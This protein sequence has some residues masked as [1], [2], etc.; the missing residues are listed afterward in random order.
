M[1]KAIEEGF[2]DEEVAEAISGIIDSR[3]RT[4]AN[5][6][7]ISGMLHHAMYFNRELSHFQEI[8]D[9]IASMTTEHVNEAFRKYVSVEK[10]TVV[11]AG[12]FEAAA[13]R[14]LEATAEEE[15][16]PTGE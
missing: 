1:I 14:A 8:D 7:S 15:T 3:I 9:N 5:D 6:G 12:D 16:E 13:K 4:R 10:F 11:T 2:E